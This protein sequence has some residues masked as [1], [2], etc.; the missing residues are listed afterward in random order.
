MSSLVKLVK[1]FYEW[2]Y[3]VLN[4][5]LAD[6][7][8][9]ENSRYEAGPPVQLIKQLHTGKLTL[10]DLEIG[11]ED[12]AV[13]IRLFNTKKVSVR[14]EWVLLSYFLEIGS[15]RDSKNRDKSKLWC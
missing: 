5:F 6:I 11:D 1:R 4:W 10:S 8:N 9:R 13:L 12:I 14:F 7:A 2:V 15:K 3:V